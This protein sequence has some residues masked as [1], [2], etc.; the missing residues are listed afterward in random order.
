MSKKQLIVVW[1]MAL[2]LSGCA[3]MEKSL[4]SQTSYNNSKKPLVKAYDYSYDIVYKAITNLLE[5][6]LKLGVNR[7]Y[8]TKDVIFSCYG[9]DS[10]FKGSYGYL[11][12]L[13]SISDE[14][15]EVSLK[16]TG[17]F[18]TISDNDMLNKYLPEE[19]EYMKRVKE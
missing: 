19:L 3:M 7:K 18:N 14:C 16:A 10:L 11:F 9:M 15:T 8:T 12:Y 13:K 2:L 4:Y 17:T 1:M 5:G 6:R